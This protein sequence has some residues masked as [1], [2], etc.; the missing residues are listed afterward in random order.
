MLRLSQEEEHNVREFQEMYSEA[1]KKGFGR[2]FRS[3][4]LFED[5]V[6]CILLCNCQWSRTLSMARALCELQMEVKCPLSTSSVH[7][8][9]DFS[10]SRIPVAEINHFLLRTPVGK[11]VKRRNGTQRDS[12]VSAI[13]IAEVEKE[14][15]KVVSFNLDYAEL[16]GTDRIKKRGT[17]SSTKKDNKF[18]ML[19][20]DSPK[21]AESPRVNLNLISDAKT[22]EITYHYSSNCTGNFPSLAE[23]ASLDEQIL[24]T[25]CKLG[26]RAKRI[27]SLARSIVEGRIQLRQLEEACSRPSLSIYN[28][29]ADQLKEIEGFGPYTCANV[30][31]CMGFYHVVPSDSETIRH[32]KQVNLQHRFTRESLTF[33]QLDEMLKLFMENLHHISTWYTGRKCG[34]SMRKGLEG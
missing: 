23:L 3:P 25:R 2:L 5:M 26:Y 34:P 32:I 24:A 12:L 28:K 17:N 14:M 20:D 4:T 18:H 16:S 11:E 31:M 8:A 27:I 6:K 15:E 30:L 19:S 29:L 9:G 33:K 1:K 10:A 22:S 7:E 21:L 13:S